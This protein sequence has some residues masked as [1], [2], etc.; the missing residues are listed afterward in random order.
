ML[1][2]FSIATALGRFNRDWSSLRR[3]LVDEGLLDRRD[4]M[5]WQI[6]GTFDVGRTP[7]G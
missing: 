5:Y 2:P 6:G 1:R 3:Y 7:A 4:G